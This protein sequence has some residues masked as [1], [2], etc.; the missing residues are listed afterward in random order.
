MATFGIRELVREFGVTAR[1]IRHYEELGLLSPSRRGQTRVYS[2]ADRT[3]LKLILRGKRLGL[4]LEESRAII[5]MYDP[6]TGSR[7]QLERLLARLRE[8]KAALLARRRDLDAMLAELEEAEAGCLGALAPPPSGT[9][10]SG[11]T[12]SR[13]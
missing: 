5:G 10:G 3:R 7:A 8:Q 2:A 13:R 11:R 9:A 4:S 6:A 12:R 1:T